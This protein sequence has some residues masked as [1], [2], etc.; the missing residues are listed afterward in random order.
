MK[1]ARS[2]F[3][4]FVGVLVASG[5]ARAEP[6]KVKYEL[7]SP[8]VGVPWHLHAK[9]GAFVC[10]LPCDAWVGARSGDYL[11]VHDTPKVW[12]VDLPSTL[13]AR[14]G[15]HVLV[16]PHVGKG[17]PALGALGTATAIT[18]AVAVFTGIVLL[19]VSFFDLAAGCDAALPGPCYAALTASLTA[20]VG[21]PLF[22]AG[23]VL[24]VVGVYLME[25]NRAASMRVHVGPTSLA[26]R[27]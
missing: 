18:G 19:G 24:A 5:V 14:D 9:D 7:T 26:V 15:E 12:R 27:F 21:A 2:C 25:H 20:Q 11:V 8:D 3:A 13:P 17:S 16:T 23:A 22:A 1:A 10:E 6:P 4:M